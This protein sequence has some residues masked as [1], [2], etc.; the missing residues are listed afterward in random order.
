MNQDPTPDGVK[1]DTIFHPSDFTDASEVAF[2]HALKIALVSKAELNMLHVD[3]DGHGGWEDFPGVRDTLA[4]WQLIPKGSGPESVGQLGIE[5]RKVVAASKH[6]V[7]ACLEFLERAPADLIV[8]AVR[9]NEGRTGWLAKS[10]GKPMVRKAGQ[11]TLFIPHGVAGFVSRADGTISLKKILIPIS[12]KPRP[13][14]AVEAVARLI[15]NFQ[16]PPGTATLLHV[17][18]APE[19]PAVKVPEDT[20]WT[21]DRLTVAG[22]AVEMILQRAA[23][24]DA[25]LI[26]MPTEGPHGFLDGLRGSTSERVLRKARCPVLSLPVGS[27]LG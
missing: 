15:H 6:P 4:R 3:A 23:E 18:T 14:P 21:W 10:V 17:G 7:E 1:I 12:N 11:M 26:V 8:L 24:L 22:E 16:L 5:V 25:D 20:G 13:L 9:Q 27:M 19:M 2:V